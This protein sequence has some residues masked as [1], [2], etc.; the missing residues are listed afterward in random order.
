MYGIQGCRINDYRQ[1]SSVYIVRD[2]KKLTLVQ[3]QD[4][5]APVA[6]LGRQDGGPTKVLYTQLAQG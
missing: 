3:F 1:Q 6:D 4:I 2:R 5:R